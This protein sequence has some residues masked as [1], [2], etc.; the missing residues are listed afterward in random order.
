[1]HDERDEMIDRIVDELRQLPAVPANATAR[2]LA[3]V[4]A[5]RRSGQAADGGDDDD[6]IFFPTNTEEMRA[7]PSAP[8]QAVPV[9]CGSA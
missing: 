5:A 6:V 9:A 3:R 1:M 2:V 7:S 8:Q 4:D